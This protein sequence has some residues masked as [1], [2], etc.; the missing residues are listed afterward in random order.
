M[1]HWAILLYERYVQLYGEPI[2]QP[3]TAHDEQVTSISPAGTAMPTQEIGERPGRS[4]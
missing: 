2:D 3:I 4:S 1:T